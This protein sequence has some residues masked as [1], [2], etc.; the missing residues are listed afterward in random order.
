M[1]QR[2]CLTFAIH[3]AW[4]TCADIICQSIIYQL[5]PNNRH[6]GITK[7]LPMTIVSVEVWGERNS[8]KLLKMQCHLRYAAG[9]GL[10]F[11]AIWI[12]KEKKKSSIVNIVCFVNVY[13]TLVLSHLYGSN[14]AWFVTWSYYSASFISHFYNNR[15]EENIYDQK[16]VF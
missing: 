15:M 6:S 2:T 9:K 5:W 16:I 3:A 8:V 14:E 13:N 10:F 12:Q 4:E 11:C 1:Q 7:V